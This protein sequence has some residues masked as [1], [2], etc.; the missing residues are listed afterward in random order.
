MNIDS[1]KN[2]YV[3]DHIPAGRGMEIYQLLGLD[4]LDC[5]IALIRNVGSRKMGKKDIIKVDCN[6][7]FNMDILGYVDPDITVNVIKNGKIVEKKTLDLPLRLV[8]VVQCKNPRCIT[9]TEQELAHIFQLTDPQKRVYRC[10]YCEAKA[11]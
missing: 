2:G 10:F 8:N 1:I 4:S 7:T 9:T 11:K 5:S 6:I 3:I